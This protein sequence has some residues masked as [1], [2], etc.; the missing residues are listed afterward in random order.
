M[1][2]R[3]IAGVQLP[4]PSRLAIEA[5]HVSSNGNLHYLNGLLSGTHRLFIIGGSPL[6]NDVW[7]ADIVQDASGS[8]SLVW[9]EMA[10][11]NNVPFSPRAGLGKPASVSS[12][13]T[14]T[15]VV[16]L[17]HASGGLGYLG[18]TISCVWQLSCYVV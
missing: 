10:S 18:S 12:L 3:R 4:A 2:C 13:N 1:R 8:W 16:C 14:P 6:T 5:A 11:G 9:E 7:A 15:V 17:E